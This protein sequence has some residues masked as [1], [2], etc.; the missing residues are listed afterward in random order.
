MFFRRSK[1]HT[2]VITCKEEEAVKYTRKDTPLDLTVNLASE[3]T[4]GTAVGRY[5]SS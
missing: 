3:L 5:L 1:A 4:P 2:K